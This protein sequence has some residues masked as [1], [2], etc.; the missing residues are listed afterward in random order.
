[1]VLLPE[2]PASR[3]VAVVPHRQRR[4]AFARPALILSLALGSPGATD[5]QGSKQAF[6]PNCAA[7]KLCNRPMEERDPKLHEVPEKLQGKAPKG[8]LKPLGHPDFDDSWAGEIDAVEDMEPETFWTKY[9][10]KKPFIMKGFAKKS[11]AFTKWKDDT[12]LLE[13]F[14]EFKAKTEPKNEDRLTDYCG[15]FKMGQKIKCGKDTIPYTET[16]MRIKKFLP[17]FRKSSF[18]KY[19]ITQM[20]DAM[21]PDFIVPNF[22]SCGKRDVA[23]PGPEGGGRWMTQMY[24]NNFWLSYNDGNNFS[25]SV[26][27]YDMNHQIMCQFDGTKEWFMWDLSSEASKIPMWSGFYKKGRHEADGSDDSPIDGERVDLM[28]WPAFKDA[29]WYNATLEAGDCLY[30]P[31]LLLHYVR[32]FGRNV[33]GMT[34]FQREERFDPQCNGETL[35]EPKPLSE[36]DVMWSFPEEDKSLLGWNV[37]KMGYP[38]WKRRYL[39]SLAKRARKSEGKKLQKQDFLKFVQGAG[40]GSGLKK[41]KAR[42]EAAWS[43]MDPAGEGAVDA[44]AIFRSRQLRFIFKDICVAQEGGRGE[45][46]EDVEVDR[47]DLKGDTQK[48]K[49]EL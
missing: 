29:K 1:M 35:G 27:H 20:P 14:G 22:H 49:M 18:D 34:M 38:N 4:W 28:R 6:H 42:T 7:R 26:I 9:W 10:P 40:K 43:E 11:P 44:S 45:Q 16:H 33:A 41:L 48:R 25:T 32:S 39:W 12:Y 8:H 31:A 2:W 36:Y 15:D 5:A 13:N 23:D 24:E 19:I 46:E 37:V 17:S 21:A 47:Y 30:T 3:D